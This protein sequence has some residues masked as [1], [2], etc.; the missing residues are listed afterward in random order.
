MCHVE[1]CWFYDSYLCI[2]RQ[3]S[4]F[5]IS[6]LRQHPPL[7]ADATT[8]APLGNMSLD[9]RVAMLSYKSSSFATPASLGAL[10]VL[11]SGVNLSL[12]QQRR[13]NHTTGLRP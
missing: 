9:F 2:H 3:N 10:W 13:E 12:W 8:F 7:V 4:I 11:G 5:V 6:C 1:L